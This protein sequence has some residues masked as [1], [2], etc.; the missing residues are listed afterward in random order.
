LSSM[1]KSGQ[2]PKTSST[3]AYKKSHH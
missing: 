3:K 1:I 2:L